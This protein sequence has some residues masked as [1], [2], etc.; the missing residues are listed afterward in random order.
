MRH[1]RA[2]DFTGHRALAKITQGY[3]APDIAREVDQDSVT[4]GESVAVLGDPVMRFD[5]D[6]VAV[7][8]EPQRFDKA[9]RHLRPIYLRISGQMGVVVA[10]GAIDLTENPHLRELA[11]GTAQS[12]RHVSQFLPEGG[13]AG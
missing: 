7:K 2:A 9:A 11:A 12:V 3:I 6:G 4:T 5:L 10:D 13:W 1:G 8:A